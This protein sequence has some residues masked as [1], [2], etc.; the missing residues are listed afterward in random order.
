MIQRSDMLWCDF[1]ITYLGFSTDTRHNAYMLRH[2][3]VE[4]PAGLRA[5]LRASMRLQDITLAESKA[6]RT[7]NDALTA[8]LAKARKG[9]PGRHRVLA[10]DRLPRP[11]CRGAAGHDRLPGRRGA[12]RFW[13]YTASTR[14]IRAW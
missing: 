6:G 10:L 3:E 9:R 12:R 8:S 2:G 5:G 11:R 7:G 14:L 1:G 13:T 4:P